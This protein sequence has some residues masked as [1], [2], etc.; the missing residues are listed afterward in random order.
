M[1]RVAPNKL[2]F[3]GQV[4]EPSLRPNRYRLSVGAAPLSSGP[5]RE[6]Q[7]AFRIVR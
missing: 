2:R 4:A 1:K 5:A 7:V 3:T 6:A